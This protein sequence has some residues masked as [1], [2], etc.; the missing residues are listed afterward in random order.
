MADVLIGIDLG[1]TVLKAAAFDRRSGRILAQASHRLPVA[2]SREGK[3]E[4]SPAALLRAL[5]SVLSSL[6]REVGSSWE[7]V[8]GMGVASQGGSTI[9]AERLSGKP[10]TPMALWNDGRAFPLFEELCSRKPA[11]FWRSFALRDEPGMGLARIEW[12]RR[13]KPAL[14]NERHIYVGAGELAF[15]WLTGAWRQDPCNALQIGC[16]DAR[17]DKLTAKPLQLVNVPLSFFAPLRHGHATRPLA[18]KAARR[19]ALARGI[20]VAGPYLDHEAGFM[21]VMDIAHRPLQCSLGTAWVGNFILPDTVRGGSPFQLPIPAPHGTGRLVIQPLLTGNVTW[22]WALTTFL[23]PD[24][25][26]ALGLQ[27]TR[28]THTLLPPEG[29]VALPWLNRP[30]HLAPGCLGAGAFFGQGPATTKEDLVRA[31][32]S[33]LVFELARVFGEVTARG[34]VDSAVLCGGASKGRAFQQLIAAI[35]HPLPVMRVTEEDWMGARGCLYAFGGTVYR[36]RAVAVRPSRRLDHDTVQAMFGLYRT[37][38]DR[39]Y[40]EV[41]AGSPFRVTSSQRRGRKRPP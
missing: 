22:D 14:I 7:S 37:I 4:Q 5:S 27:K 17:R 36:A 39:L 15:H 9:I 31:V 2:L 6:R 16:Y 38:F 32:A 18:A 21:A 20:P 28:F 34:L 10:L 25:T 33:G 30:N 12:L 40:G 19:L 1:T 41:P 23:H 35:F 24:L 3:R 11:G 29:L 26:K 13:T 8:R